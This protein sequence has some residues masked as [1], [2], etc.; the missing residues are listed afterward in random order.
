MLCI[1]INQTNPSNYD[2]NT[3]LNICIA[4]KRDKAMKKFNK[5]QHT[6]SLNHIQKN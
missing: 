2:E 1:T 3:T 6:T 5:T 4:Y